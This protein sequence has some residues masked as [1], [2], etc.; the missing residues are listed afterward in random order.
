MG[1]DYPGKDVVEGENVYI[2]GR[3]KLPWHK[4]KRQWCEDLQLKQGN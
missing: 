1:W 3:T 2:T 4:V